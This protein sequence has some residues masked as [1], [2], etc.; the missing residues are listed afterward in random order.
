MV[1]VYHQT[2]DL[3]EYEDIRSWSPVSSIVSS[4]EWSLESP[5]ETLETYRSIVLIY[6]RL[7][8]DECQA[9][10]FSN[11]SLSDVNI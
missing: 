9:S 10:E 1:F 3:P 4:P 8:G 7:P 2:S 11:R 5:G 6:T